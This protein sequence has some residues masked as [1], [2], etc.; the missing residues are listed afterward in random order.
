VHLL[1][2]YALDEASYRELALELGGSEGA[3][4]VRVHKAMAALRRHIR[5]CH[6]ELEALL[7]R[8]RRTPHVTEGSSPFVRVHL[9]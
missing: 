9:E 3:L 6:P 5:E 2:R 8:G 7:E 4:R 1:H